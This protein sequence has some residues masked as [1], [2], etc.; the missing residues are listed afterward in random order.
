MLGQ[1]DIKLLKGMMESVID[2]RMPKVIESVIDERL[3]KTENFMLDE[4]GR[5]QV[6]LENK[7]N[8]VQ[9]NLEELNQYYRITK[10]ENDNTALLLKMIDELSKRVEE[11]EKKTA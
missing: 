6:Y 7:I 2:E 1:D 4:I 11:L 5:T 3:S 9:K 10:L 8:K